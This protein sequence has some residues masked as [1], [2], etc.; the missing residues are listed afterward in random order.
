[1][2]EQEVRAFHK[3]YFS[4]WDCMKLEQMVCLW[5][6][7]HNGIRKHLTTTRGEHNTP[8]TSRYTPSLFCY[9]PRS[10]TNG[11]ISEVCR[12]PDIGGRNL[13]PRK[14]SSSWWK[15]KSY[16]RWRC[17]PKRGLE[18]NIFKVTICEQQACNLVHVNV[19]IYLLVVAIFPFS[20]KPWVLEHLPCF[21]DILIRFDP[22]SSG[23]TAII[24]KNTHL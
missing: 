1:M 14:E 20:T 18:F 8:M 4:L 9:Q 17:T 5:T 19:S 12:P 22:S 3:R 10:F 15:E 6:F 23:D 24:N 7:R 21:S 2:I 13:R 16:K 11:E